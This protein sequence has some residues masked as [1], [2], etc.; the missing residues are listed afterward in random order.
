MAFRHNRENATYGANSGGFRHLPSGLYV[1][2]IIRCT[3]NEKTNGKSR[4]EFDYDIVKGEYK[5]FFKEEYDKFSQRSRSAFWTGN[6]WQYY[7]GKSAGYMDALINRFEDS[8]PS[9]RYRDDGGRCFEGFK[10][11]ASIQAVETENESGF[12][13]YRYYVRNTYSAKE[14]RAKEDYDGNPL[15]VYEDSKYEKPDTTEQETSFDN[16]PNDFGISDDD[17][18]F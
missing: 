9:F 11:V 5:D 2:N 6:F 18:E 10:I 3:E 8:N 16:A 14:T 7:E 12:K 1:I 15:K 13:N 4:F 17:I